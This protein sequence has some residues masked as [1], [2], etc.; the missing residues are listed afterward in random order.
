MRLLV[1]LS[2]VLL[3]GCLA[4]APKFPKPT[5]EEVMQSCPNL[6]LAKTDSDKLTDL[7]DTIA[8]NYKEYYEC[9]D[10]VDTWIKWYK[11]QKENYE[12]VGK[13]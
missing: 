9:R 1:V 11:Q 12:K 10:K 8:D 5:S 4:S 7:M 6:K 13:L 2:A 3:T